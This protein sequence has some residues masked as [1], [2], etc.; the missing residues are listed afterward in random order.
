MPKTVKQGRRA[1]TPKR[2]DKKKIDV[3]DRST[4]EFTDIDTFDEGDGALHIVIN[5]EKGP[6]TD[7]QHE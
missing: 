2:L 1:L 5:T 4:G 6:K 7:D 3:E